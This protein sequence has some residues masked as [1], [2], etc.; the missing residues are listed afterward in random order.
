[1]RNTMRKRLVF[2][3]SIFIFLILLGSCSSPYLTQAIAGHFRIM[4][5]RQSIV[6]LIHS[7]RVDEETRE[8]L[9]LVLEIRDFASNEL[10]LPSN[11]SY[12]KF[13]KLNA[14][15]P[16]WN[17][18][19]APQL[20]VEP[21]TW[22][23]PIAGCVVYHGYFKKEKAMEFAKKMQEEQYDVYVSPFTAYSTLGWFADPIL[24]TNL[25]EDSIDLAGLIFHE[26]AHQRFYLPGNSQV[27]ESFAVTVE[28]NGVIRWLKTLG[29]Q[30]LIT[31]ATKRWENEERY[32][33]RMLQT[34]HELEEL[35]LSEKDSASM[36]ESKAQILVTLENEL[37]NGNRK[38]NNA[39]FIPISTY[40]SLVPQFQAIFDSCKGDFSKFYEAMEAQTF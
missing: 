26:L 13:A 37:F 30:D 29:K 1:M 14:E 39:H 3:L 19:C 35:Y 8:K 22:C 5:S 32:F 7:N 23:F 18:F 9:K 21:K 12:T 16:G 38:L 25:N 4:N 33:N 17:V 31:K 27:S 36:F 2:G 10:G 6:K 40:N 15:Y 20:S 28:R 24:S 34:K 11:K